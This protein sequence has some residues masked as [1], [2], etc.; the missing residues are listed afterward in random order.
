MNLFLKIAA[1]IYRSYDDR[2]VDIPYFRAIMTIVIILF[3]HMVHIGIIFEIPSDFIL[4]WDS[5]ASKPAKYFFGFIYFS[6]FITIIAFLFKKSKLEKVHISKKEVEIA[7][8]ILPIY[9]AAC[10]ILLGILLLRAGIA[11]GTINL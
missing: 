4:P 6:V 9:L 11:K 5:N 7:R 8:K 1:I 10:I 3:L 2:G